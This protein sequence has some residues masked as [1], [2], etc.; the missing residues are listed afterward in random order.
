MEFQALE[1]WVS[2]RWSISSSSWEIF[3]N[4]KLIKDRLSKNAKYVILKD[5]FAQRDVVLSLRDGRPIGR[6]MIA[7][8]LATIADYIACIRKDW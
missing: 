3:E 8:S 4:T 2:G 1:D 7:P 5:Y 6:V